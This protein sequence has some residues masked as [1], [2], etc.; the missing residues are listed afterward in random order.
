MRVQVNA[1]VM[2][3]ILGNGNLEETFAPC[4]RSL[5]V[6][7]ANLHWY[8]KGEARVARKMGHINLVGASM[9]DVHRRLD[10]VTLGT[11]LPPR[12]PLVAI[13]MGSDS[14]LGVM[15]PAAGA[16]RAVVPARGAAAVALG[17]VLTAFLLSLGVRRP[18]AGVFHRDLEAV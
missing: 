18:G 7:G 4:A 3:N 13:I 14:Y 12:A 10:A 2:L 11:A 8:N 15:R 5:G 1:A 9:S 17:H 16:S 6:P